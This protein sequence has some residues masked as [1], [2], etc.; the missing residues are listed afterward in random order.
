MEREGAIYLYGCHCSNQPYTINERVGRLD[1][2]GPVYCSDS[3]V[4]L[5]EQGRLKI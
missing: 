5:L 1:V 2:E 4:L 3:L